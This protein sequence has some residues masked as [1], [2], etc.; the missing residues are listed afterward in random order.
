MHIEACCR[1][2]YSFSWSKWLG[3]WGREWRSVF[4]CIGKSQDLVACESACHRC[5]PMVETS[6][7]LWDLPAR[8]S[9]VSVW[10]SWGVNCFYVRIATVSNFFEDSVSSSVSISNF[11]LILNRLLDQ[12]DFL[13]VSRGIKS[14]ELASL[15]SKR[16]LSSWKAN[17]HVERHEEVTRWRLRCVAFSDSMY[18]R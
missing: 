7:G 13:V 6:Y 2:C 14:R 1:C 18:E 5:A 15:L 8:R 17:K 16:S 3:T 4:K 9:L 11:S 12:V 10:L